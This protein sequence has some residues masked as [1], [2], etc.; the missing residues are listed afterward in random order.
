MRP[1]RLFFLW[2]CSFASVYGLNL[3][4]A[5]AW[6]QL[7]YNSA[8]LVAA[9]VCAPIVYLF[10]GWLYFRPGFA[11]KRSERLWSALLWI[12]LDF[13]VGML[14]LSGTDGVKPTDMFSPASLVIESANLVAVLLAGYLATTHTKPERLKISAKQKPSVAADTPSTRSR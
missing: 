9:M 7:G 14:L 8:Y 11:Q 3:L 10:F 6:V 13:V 12:A 2:L 5:T 1:T 4:A